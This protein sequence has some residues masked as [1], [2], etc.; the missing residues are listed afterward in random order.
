MTPITTTAALRAA[1]NSLAFD[2]AFV[3]T[4]EAEALFARLDASAFERNGHNAVALVGALPDS[5]LEE[6]LASGTLA[7]EVARMVA[8]RADARG[9]R[10]WDREHGEQALLVA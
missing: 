5:R 9:P 2:L 10:W 8:A 7:A 4:P 1:L 3:S 6:G